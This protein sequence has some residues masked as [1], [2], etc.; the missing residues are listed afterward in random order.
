M[1]LLGTP[2]CQVLQDLG[3]GQDIRIFLVHIKKVDGVGRLV[4][5]ENAF[6]YHSHSVPV[7]ASVHDRGT[8]TTTGTLATSDDGIHA[9]R[10]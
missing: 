1:V 10:V 8:N 9:Q 6:L 3:Q 2:N 7:G 5:V 4:T